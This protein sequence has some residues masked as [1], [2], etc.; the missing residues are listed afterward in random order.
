MS[1]SASSKSKNTYLLNLYLYQNHA[2]AEASLAYDRNSKSVGQSA[3]TSKS[4]KEIDPSS[5]GR[6]HSDIDM[7]TVREL[8]AFMREI[9]DRCILNKG[10]ADQTRKSTSGRD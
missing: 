7:Q 10:R 9:T 1:K 5:S 6:S 3:A 2:A 4:E 8:D